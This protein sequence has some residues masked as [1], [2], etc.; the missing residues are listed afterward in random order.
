MSVL[1][2]KRIFHWVEVRIAPQE[3]TA[4]ALEKAVRL[5]SSA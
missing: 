3:S 2:F 5:G 4:R 1:Q